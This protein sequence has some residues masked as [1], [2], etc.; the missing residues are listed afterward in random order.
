MY[1]VSTDVQEFRDARGNVLTP[2]VSLKSEDGESYAHIVKDGSCV[3]LWLQDPSVL[4]EV[5]K[6]VYK[7]TSHMIR[8]AIE[9]LRFLPRETL[10]WRDL[11]LTTRDRLAMRLKMGSDDTDTRVTLAESMYASLS[12]GERELLSLASTSKCPVWAGD[13]PSTRDKDTLCALGL[14]TPVVYQG[15]SGHFCL[16]VVG[17]FVLKAGAPKPAGF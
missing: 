7:V 3:T 13:L 12:Y 10:N 15:E 4:H 6:P 5:G 11:G 1:I 16:T 14:L 8:E 17:G 9:V 2:M